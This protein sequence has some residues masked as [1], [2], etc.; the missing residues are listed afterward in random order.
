MIGDSFII[1]DSKKV[2]MAARDTNTFAWRLRSTRDALGITQFEMC[3]RIK[4]I[5]EAQRTD[6]Q[7]TLS[8]EMRGGNRVSRLE[9]IVANGLSMLE[10]E[11]VPAANAWFRRH[12][13]VWIEANEVKSVNPV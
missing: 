6:V 11:D 9:E 1:T 12:F 5:V 3:D 13:Q 2:V 8:G 10:R 4:S 7:N